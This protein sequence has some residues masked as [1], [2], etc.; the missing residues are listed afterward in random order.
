MSITIGYKQM[1]DKDNILALKNALAALHIILQPVAVTT[2]VEQRPFGQPL[3][4]LKHKPIPEYHAGKYTVYLL[5]TSMSAV[6]QVIRL[7][8]FNFDA[9][10]LVAEGESKIIRKLTGNLVI[11]K[12]KPS[13]YSFS[14]NRYGDVAGTDILRARFSAEVFRRMQLSDNSALRRNAFVALIERGDEVYTAQRLVENSNIEVRVKRYHIGSPLHRYLYTEN[15]GSTQACGSITRWSRFDQP[16]VCFDWRHPLTDDQG[17]RLADEPISDDYASVWLHDMPSA[18]A[19]AR[20]S[21]LFLEDLFHDAGLQ[22]IDIC[23]FV[24]KS[25]HILYGEI[26]PDCMRV[27]EINQDFDRVDAYDKDLWREGKSALTL[28]QRYEALY[29]RAF[30]REKSQEDVCNNY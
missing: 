22:L 9:L 20:S 3:L 12:F 13:V 30:L 28:K 10:P 15:Y 14:K 24:D 18:K 4:T 6:E 25:G 29:Y 8:H 1:P 16:L 26:S 23:Y 27:R 5:D 7:L 19:L 2:P 17:K 21:F 11:E